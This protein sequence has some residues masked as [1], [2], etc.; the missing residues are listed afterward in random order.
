MS[1]CH[2]GEASASS[3]A[4]LGVLALQAVGF[5]VIKLMTHIAPEDVVAHGAAVRARMSVEVLELWCERSPRRLYYHDNSVRKIGQN[6]L[7]YSKLIQAS[8]GLAGR[9]EC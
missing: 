5:D 6:I 2:F 1:H 4:Q 8:S 3:I 7:V 9:E